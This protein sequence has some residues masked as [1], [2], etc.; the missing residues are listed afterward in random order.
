[1]AALAG[2]LLSSCAAD[3]GTE[4]GDAVTVTVWHQS[5]GADA[6]TFNSLVDDFNASQSDYVVKAEFSPSTGTDFTP[7]LVS[8][9]QNGDA[10]NLVVG[11]TNPSGL[12]T[13]IETG[14]ILPLADMLGTGDTP[15]D[16]NNMPKGMADTGTFDGDLYALAT[17]G[18]NFAILYNKEK[19][20][21]AGIKDVP[22]TWDEFAQAAETLTTDGQYGA[23]LPISGGNW[24]SFTWYSML[25][26]A[27]GSI[28]SDDQSTVTFNDEAGVEA[29]TAWTDMVEA[30][31]AFPSSLG[32]NS[33]PQGLP[34][35]LS[36]QVAMMFGGA[37]M[38]GDA[39]AALGADNVGV[40]AVPALGDEPGM[41]IGTDVSYI[42]DGADEEDAGAWAFLSWFLQPEH[43][44]TWDIATGFFPTNSLTQENEEFKAHVA[45]DPRLQVFIDELEYAT[46]RPSVVSFTEIDNAVID[47]IEG[48][49]LLQK[50]PKAALDEAAAA[51]QKVLD[52][53]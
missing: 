16:L 37:Y 33:S 21:A 10:P 42:I 19:F 4:S 5:T 30:G 27:G 40:F 46:A 2:L 38:L 50:S 53:E 11:D 32:D 14:K 41:T 52:N 36:G 29:L 6:A 22:A 13:A 17:D 34:G 15:F 31:S 3:T 24:P 18:G 20:A 45:E 44:A 35:F 39:D 47:A 43:Q 49:M 28:L 26:S 48:A 7:R 23:Y 51:A 9:I 12:G 1:M 25:A 8:A